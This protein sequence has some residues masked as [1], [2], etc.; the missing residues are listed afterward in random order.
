MNGNRNAFGRE[1]RRLRE[2]RGLTVGELAARTNYARQHMARIEQGERLPTSKM[3]A[4]LDDVLEADG[5]LLA[6]CAAQALQQSLNTAADESAELTRLAR[7]EPV[8]SLTL[9]N[10]AARVS[11]IAQGYVHK[12]PLPLVN[13][14]LSTR[15]LIRQALLMG[16]RPRRARELYLL[17]AVTMQLLAECTDDLAGDTAAAMKHV[18]A[19]E[20][21]AADVGHRGLEA[22]IKG[23]KALIVEWS[24]TPGAALSILEDATGWA[25]PGDHRVR[26]WALRARCAARVGDIAL[27]RSSAARVVAAAEE[28]AAG[29]E[30]NAFGGAMQFPLAKMAYYLGGTYRRIGDHGQAELWALNAIQRY[31]SGPEDRRSYGDEGLARIDAGLARIADNEL[32]GAGDVLKPVLEL[33]PDRRIAPIMEGMRTVTAALRS[34][35]HTD[36]PV[37][38]SLIEATSAYSTRLTPAVR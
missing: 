16:P 23:T 36:A 14:L 26:L 9:D 17:A 21:L 34:H 31:A 10:L 37:A 11:A 29:D 1:V 25:P 28:A 13:E 27:A 8:S 33:P 35:R 6:V 24:P 18:S 12:A 3:A 7:Y 22:W 4:R 20:S 32:E 2:E 19:A 5:A 38:K 15:S 30:V